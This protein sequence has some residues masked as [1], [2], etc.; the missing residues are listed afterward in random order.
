MMVVGLGHGP[1]YLT[2]P[3]DSPRLLP[4]GGE[5]KGGGRMGGSLRSAVRERE[6][7][8]VGPEDEAGGNDEGRR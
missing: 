4:R 5:N 2:R 8:P 3:P 1:S 7:R 6:E